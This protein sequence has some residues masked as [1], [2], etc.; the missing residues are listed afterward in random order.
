MSRF[1]KN[2]VVIDATQWFKNGDH[3][4]DYVMDRPWQENG[5]IV[6][7]AGAFFR[8]HEYEGGIVRYYRRP[9]DS[10][11]RLCKHCRVRMHEH[12][13]I[14]TKEGGHIVCPADF[15]ITGVQGE[16]YPCKPEIFCATYE[17]AE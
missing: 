5:R 14:D 7:K 17:P 13:W 12:G 10:G 6:M 3:P 1:R 16:Y 11:E 2:P 15:I 8:A 9:N 4:D